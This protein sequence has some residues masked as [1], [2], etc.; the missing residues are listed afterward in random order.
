MARNCNECLV[1]FAI[2]SGLYDLMSEFNNFGIVTGPDFL[3]L[4]D[5]S[6]PKVNFYLTIEDEEY[7][8]S[9][10]FEVAL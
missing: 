5:E 6:T 1:E 4:D 3:Y 2:K 9:K 7:G 10:I 8:L